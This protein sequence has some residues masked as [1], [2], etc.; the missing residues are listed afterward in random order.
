[1]PGRHERPPRKKSAL[2]NLLVIGLATAGALLVTVAL[3]GFFTSKPK[4]AP[5]P[6]PVVTSAAPSSPGPSVSTLPKSPPTRLDVAAIDVHTELMQL[7]LNQDHTVQVPPLTKD[8]P[9]GWYRNSPTP[10]QLGPAIILGHVDTAKYGPAVFYKLGKLK[11]GDQIRVTR[12]DAK[13]A[14]FRVDEVALYSKKQFPTQKV[15]G[16]IDHAGL[17][18]ITCGGTFDFSERSYEDNTV[19]FASLV[20]TA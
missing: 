6:T 10:G 4:A 11:P 12:A 16:D 9:A 3:T 19:V 20:A 7:G 8:A 1:M 17:R 18:L 14:V 13:V 2:G 5:P 15:Y